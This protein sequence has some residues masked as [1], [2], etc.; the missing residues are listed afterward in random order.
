MKLKTKLWYCAIPLVSVLPLSIIAC[1]QCAKEEKNPL[2]KFGKLEISPNFKTKMNKFYPSLISKET[3]KK[4]IRISGMDHDEFKNY[5][6]EDIQYDDLNGEAIITVDYKK[7]YQGDYIIRKF[8]L[9]GF[10]KISK[11]ELS[12]NNREENIVP[13]DNKEIDTFWNYLNEK[14]PYYINH[15]I[16]YDISYDA[17][18]R[19]LY[20]TYQGRKVLLSKELNIAKDEYLV[21]SEINFANDEHYLKNDLD[22]M[23]DPLT[24]YLEITYRVAKQE[25]SLTLI[26][27]TKTLKVVFFLKPEIIN[28][29]NPANDKLILVPESDSGFDNEIT[30]NLLIMSDELAKNKEAIINYLKSGNQLKVIRTTKGNELQNLTICALIQGKEV[31]IFTANDNLLD[32]EFY[33][34]NQIKPALENND[35]NQI[36]SYQYDEKT[37]TLTLKYKLAFGAEEALTYFSNDHNVAYKLD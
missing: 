29:E 9:G 33:L 8:I 3:L 14:S 35:P 7:I 2:E 10:R 20:A 34:V 5:N 28:H 17:D 30:E 4:E 12:T 32:N 26:S 13:L 25:N 1:N 36:L 15:N 18:E 16:Q 11:W 31:A 21:N 23:V 22:I 6:I 27:K 24:R 19:V 37:N